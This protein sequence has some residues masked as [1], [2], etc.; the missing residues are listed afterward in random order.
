[1]LDDLDDMKLRH[2]MVLT[3]D[4]NASLRFWS[5]GLGLETLAK[6]DSWSEVKLGEELTLAIKYASSEA[7]H[8]TGY[9]P[10]VVFDVEDLDNLLY[11]A[12]EAGA[13]M[14][15]PVKYPAFGKVASLRSPDGVMIG[16]FEETKHD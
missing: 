3:R 9:H 2:V 11:K 16:L 14:D 5:G 6:S 4:M 8:S 12:M 7:L 13:T 10:Q 1:M 15:G